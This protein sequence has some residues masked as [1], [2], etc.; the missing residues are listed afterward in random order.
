M[1]RFQEFRPDLCIDRSTCASSSPTP[2][3]SSSSSRTGSELL[4]AVVAG[5]YQLEPDPSSFGHA[6]TLMEVLPHCERPGTAIDRASSTALWQHEIRVRD[7]GVEFGMEFLPLP[8]AGGASGFALVL[9][10]PADDESAPVAREY[11]TKL[12]AA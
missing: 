12:V 11:F 2:T 10:H 7:H 8:F 5:L 6:R 9:A 3:G 1:R 4:E